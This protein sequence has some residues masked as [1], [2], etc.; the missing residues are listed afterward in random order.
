MLHELTSDLPDFKHATFSPGLNVV[1]AE[2]TKKAT[3]QDSRNAVGKTS[4]IKVL[5]FLLAAEARPNHVVR[6]RELEHGT[7]SLSIDLKDYVEQVSRS[8]DNAGTVFLG[9]EYMRIRD[10]RTYLGQTLFNLQGRAGEPAYRSLISFYLR[11]VMSGAFSKATETHRKQAS[12]DTLPALTWLFGLDLG[13]VDKVKDVLQTERS[14]DDLRRAARDPVL[15]MTIGRSRDLE[16]S[17]TTLRIEQERMMRELADFQVVDRYT[18]YRAQ[19]DQLSREIRALNES[20]FMAERQLKDIGESIVQ[21]N[22]EQPDFEYIQDMYGEAGVVLSDNV[23]RRFDEVADFH[24]SVVTNRRRYLESEQAK[25]TDQISSDRDHLADLDSKRASIMR[26]LEAGGALETYNQLQRD[27]GTLS[28]RLS[29]L[30]ERRQTVDRW[31]NA[32][33]H[34]QLR[35][36]E[37]EILL[38]SDLTERSAQ[39]GA[40]GRMYS[41]F[42]YR[43]YGGQR[44]ASLSIESS[45]SGYRFLP[46]IG[47][48][49]SERVRSISIF[50]FDLTMA[51]TARRLGRGPDFLVHDSH[52]YDSVEARQVASALNLAADV[53][54]EEGL[55]YIVTLNSDVLEKAKSE[56]FRSDYHES[57]HMTDAYDSGGLFGI[58][59]N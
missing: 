2:R 22:A 7:F 43:I 11:D 3:S 52:L 57:A 40:I 58:R 10:W 25:L 27:L 34:L 17:I 44:P 38:S 32:N 49:S 42:A 15:G 4:L 12:I 16:A 53:A 26:I 20:L 30:E 37:L 21:E 46:T 41:G 54:K 56:G 59:F 35:A 1:L 39:V 24:R 51:V 29:E 36:A 48:D 50:C 13:L 8:G 47:G 14:L 55:Q 45:R 31:E 5:D 33:R 28:G 9:Q 19:A 18:E 6:R 23:R